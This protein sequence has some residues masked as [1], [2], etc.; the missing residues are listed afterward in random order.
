MPIVDKTD[1]NAIDAYTAERIKNLEKALIRTLKWCAES[2]VNTARVSHTY[3]DQT[4]NLTSSI[5]AVIVV[6]G[7]IEWQSSF[8]VVKQGGQGA[9]D[10]LEFAKSLVKEFPKGIALIVVAGKNYAVHVSNRGYDVID[11]AELEAK[12]LI[13][14][15][16]QSLKI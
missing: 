8:E 2:I 6:D 13:P 5:G 3:K 4:G 16:L 14:Q 1:Y 10:G 15:M 7:H 9:K 12:T 11:S